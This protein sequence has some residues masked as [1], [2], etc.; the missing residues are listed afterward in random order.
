MPMSYLINRSKKLI[1]LIGTGELTDTDMIACITE[2]RQD[3]ALEADMSTLSSMSMV[4][5][6]SITRSGVRAV[7][8]VMAATA[9]GR[10]EARAAIVV[11]GD[12]HGKMAN[13]L[14]EE[15][16]DRGQSLAFSVFRTHNEASSWLQAGH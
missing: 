12:L 7:V 16:E 10:G 1:T 3:P 8:D 2:M 15:A 9:S 13:F 11:S 4:D 14:R 5:R 6:L